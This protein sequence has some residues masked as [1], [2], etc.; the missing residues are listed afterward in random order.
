MYNVVGLLSR[1]PLPVLTSS[2]VATSS[3][4][5][6]CFYK[7]ILLVL[8]SIGLGYVQR[9]AGGDRSVSETSRAIADELVSSQKPYHLLTS[10]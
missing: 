4:F 2:T 1:I 10:A 9:R 5:L 7:G 8:G 6:G 3:F